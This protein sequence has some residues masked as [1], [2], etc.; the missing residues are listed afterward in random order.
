MSY[1]T[2]LPASHTNAN[3]F[4]S[5]TSAVSSPSYTQSLSYGTTLNARA[6]SLSPAN[7]PAYNAL[8]RQVSSSP[9]MP[10]G[11]SAVPSPLSSRG[12]KARPSS[13]PFRS[14]ETPGPI[15]NSNS[16]SSSS[17]GGSGGSSISAGKKRKNSS[18]LP[19]HAPYS[20]E[21][22]SSSSS[23]SVYQHLQCQTSA[24][25]GIL[26]TILKKNYWYFRHT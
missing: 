22:S 17:S 20:A 10:S 2:Y 26:K 11:H 16:N 14:R 9:Q 24:Y 4:L 18:P 12:P 13:K 7:H 15:A 6:S 21:S 23:S 3:G 8:S 5:P 25:H 19:T 1:S